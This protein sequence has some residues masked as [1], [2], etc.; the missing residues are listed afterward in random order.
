MFDSLT[1]AQAL[2]LTVSVTPRREDDRQTIERLMRQDPEI[3]A[4]LRRTQEHRAKTT[5]TRSRGKRPWVNRQRRTLVARA[6]AGATWTMK[7]LPSLRRDLESVSD[8]ITV[9]PA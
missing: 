1:P 3:K 8:F 9:T 6:E 2:T 4:A 7:Y 5:I